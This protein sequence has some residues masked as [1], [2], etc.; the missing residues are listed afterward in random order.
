[1]EFMP[2]SSGRSPFFI[3]NGSNTKIVNQ[4]QCLRQTRP[5]AYTFDGHKLFADLR[6]RL[7]EVHA[8][9]MSYDRLAT[10]AGI[11]KSTSHRW[12]EHFP[13]QQL[14]AWFCW[15]EHLPAEER[16]TYG[17]AHCRVLP[18]LAHP[19]LS[20]SPRA[21]GQILKLMS[22]TTGLTLAV[23]D[24]DS[25]EFLITAMG[26]AVNAED[27]RQRLVGGLDL[28]VPKDYVP[29]L[30][31]RYLDPA[32]ET[33]KLRQVV[34]AALP[35]LI[36]SRAPLLIFRGV[37]FRVPAV[38]DDLLRRARTK[39][40]LVAELGLPDLSEAKPNDTAPAHLLS[41]KRVRLGIGIKCRRLN[42]A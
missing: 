11:S 18:S 24:A 28:H 26:H 23:G 13:H 3:E 37:W 32:S 20:H 22:Q 30:A 19:R 42:A 39:H 16:Q 31:M 17:E 21:V 4:S 25:T 14:R 35:G 1:M 10:L 6:A 41:L 7:E 33:K 8:G 27:S 2:G 15:L 40:V 34:I 36:T 38:R 29:V 12:F 9:R 5:P